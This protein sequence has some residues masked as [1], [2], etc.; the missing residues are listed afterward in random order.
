[1]GKL[2][3]LLFS[4]PVYTLDFYAVIIMRA[5]LSLRGGRGGWGGGVVLSTVV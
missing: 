5:A 1:M 2:K 3:Q 4:N